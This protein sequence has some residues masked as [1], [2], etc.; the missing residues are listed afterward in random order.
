VDNV[1][2]E[3][4]I[5]GDN[6]NIDLIKVSNPSELPQNLSEYDG[7]ISWHLVPLSED[8]VGILDNCK[9]IVR[10]AVG[11]DNIDIDCAKEK[12]IIVAN[13]PDYG[14]E[15][16]ADHMLALLLGLVRKIYI[17]NNHVIQGGWQWNVIGDTI[18]L[19]DAEIGLLGF[20]R[21]GKAVAVRAKAFCLKVSFFDPYVPSGE[22]KSLGVNRYESLQDMLKNVDFLSVHAPLNEETHHLIGFEEFDKMKNG[23]I[24]IN[25]A[26]GGI[27]DTNA[28]LTALN[29]GKI[30]ALGLDVVEEEPAIPKALLDRDNVLI[31]PHS[32]FYSDKALYDIRHKSARNILRYFNNEFIRDQVN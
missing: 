6:F 3:K 32:A 4:E 28:M 12:G 14:T 1:S 8:V 31:T 20:G 26:R 27:I 5:L 13:V 2:I 10:A 17:S 23:A 25:C 22:E 19:S 9:I 24:L 15:E 16:V 18:R 7:I 11:F 30:S 29:T 21:I